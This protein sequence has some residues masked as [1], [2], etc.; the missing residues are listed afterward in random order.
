MSRAVERE[1][2]WSD[3]WNDCCAHYFSFL[4][5]LIMAASCLSFL[6][7]AYNRLKDDRKPSLY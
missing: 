3:D 5:A 2:L 4:G 6:M 7:A 1:D